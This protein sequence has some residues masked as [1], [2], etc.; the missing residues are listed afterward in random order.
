MHIG[1]D[2]D[3]IV[4]SPQPLRLRRGRARRYRQGSVTEVV[5]RAGSGRTRAERLRSSSQLTLVLIVLGAVLSTLGVPWWAAVAGSVT[6]VAAVAAGQ[7]RAAQAG[8]FALPRDP[9]A[10]VLVAPPER[11]AY[12]RALAMARRVRRTWPALR[13]MIDIADADRTLTAALRDLAEVMA[14][15]QQ[16]RRLR[17]ELGAGAGHG[18]P[19]DS[20]ALRALKEQRDRVGELWRTSGDEANRILAGIHATALAGESFV[21]E[22]HVHETARDAELALSRLAPPAGPS[23]D[24][25]PALAERTAAVV[26]AYRELAA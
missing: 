13:N 14:R 5:P 6:L 2:G 1:A 16:L 21:R 26:A 3:K 25:A 20:P 23:P 17:E 15:R 12:S 8:A 22:L 11:A 24:T 19:A 4:V 10:R 7:A 18:L 9:E